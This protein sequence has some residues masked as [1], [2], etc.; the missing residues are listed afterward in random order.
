[1]NYVHPIQDNPSFSS[2]RRWEAYVTVSAGPNNY[3]ASATIIMCCNQHKLCKLTFII[4][5]HVGEI[6]NTHSFVPVSWAN[7]SDFLLCHCYCINGNQRTETAEAQAMSHYRECSLAPR[8][9][10]LLSINLGTR[11]LRDTN[12]HHDTVLSTAIYVLL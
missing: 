8:L 3:F 2:S 10:H 6:F 9:T 4:F 11:L 7:N 12:V 1:M 5:T